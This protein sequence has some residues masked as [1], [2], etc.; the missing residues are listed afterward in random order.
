MRRSFARAASI[1]VIALSLAAPVYAQEAAPDWHPESSE[2]LVKLPANY[3]RKSLDRDFAESALGTALQGANS[4]LNNK[5]KSLADLQAA[6]NRADGDLK[7]ELRHQFLQEKRSY[8]EL[9][10]QRNDLQRKHVRIQTRLLEDMLDR[11]RPMNG[12]M[13]PVREELIKKQE[14]ARSRFESSLANVDMALFNDSAMKESKYS[15]KYSE[16]SAAI[17]QLVARIQS[18]NMNEQPMMD[19]ETMTKEDYVRQMLA[20]ANAE[21]A[22]VD[23]EGTILGYM[24]KLVALDA[25]QLAEEALNPDFTDVAAADKAG[26]AANV[27]FFISN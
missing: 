25:M 11:M 17:E 21:A 15:A 16:N 5:A 20:D 22:L 19:G 1:A 9:M 7:I 23:Q 24:A 8:V 4:E 26:P 14:A 10:S 18:H 13:S 6:I 27:H 2:R 12:S 3:L